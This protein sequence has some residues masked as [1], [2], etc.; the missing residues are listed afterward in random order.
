MFVSIDIY[1][2]IAKSVDA[3]TMFSMLSVN[4]KFKSYFDYIMSIKYPDLISFK[5]RV[6]DIRLT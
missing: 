4:K 3:K 1:L 2:H 5:K 6:S